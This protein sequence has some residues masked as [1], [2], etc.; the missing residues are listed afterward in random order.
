MLRIAAL[1]AGRLRPQ[2]P[3]TTVAKCRALSAMPYPDADDSAQPGLSP[4]HH[5]AGEALFSVFD[6]NGRGSFGAGELF[7]RASMAAAGFA[8]EVGACAGNC[9]CD[10]RAHDTAR[11]CRCNFRCEWR[12]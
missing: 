12:K 1:A 11:C 6:S 3:A 2:R 9:R 8:R 4:Q 7:V 5:D 10:Q